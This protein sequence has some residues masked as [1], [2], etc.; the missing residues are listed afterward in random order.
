MFAYPPSTTVERPDVQ[1]MRQRKDKAQILALVMWIPA[2]LS[3]FV[4][5]NSEGRS[6]ERSNFGFA[7]I[8]LRYKSRK[9]WSHEPGVTK[10][11]DQQRRTRS[12]GKRR[13]S[14][15]IVVQ[16]RRFHPCATASL[17]VPFLLQPSQTRIR[18]STLESHDSHRVRNTTDTA[19]RHEKPLSREI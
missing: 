3:A 8:Y 16:V 15:P 18:L 4:Q 12:E 19:T 11:F 7:F 9:S 13:T 10:N 2:I 1:T 14:A 17:H 5:T 6:N